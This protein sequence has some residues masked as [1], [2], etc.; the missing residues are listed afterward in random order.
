M[1]TT[2]IVH[3]PQTGRY[4]KTHYNTT[5]EASYNNLTSDITEAQRFYEDDFDYVDFNKAFRVE[6]IFTAI[7]VV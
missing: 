7:R 6:E 2:Y 4:I 3:L 5:S 1:T